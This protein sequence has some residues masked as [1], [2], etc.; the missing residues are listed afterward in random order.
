MLTDRCSH[1]KTWNEPCHECDLVSAR[2]LVEHW[3]K[4]VDEARE[5]IAEAEQQTTE[6]QR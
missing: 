4:K 1:G 3:G 5:L 6:E 2:Q